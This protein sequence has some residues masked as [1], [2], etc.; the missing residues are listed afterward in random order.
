MALYRPAAVALLLSASAWGADPPPEFAASGVVAGARPAQILAPGAILSIYG[1]YLAAAGSGCVG[2]PDPQRQET[3]NPRQPFR[4]FVNTS[5]YPK[6]LCGVRVMVGEQ[7]AGLLYISEK[8]INFKVPM[9]APESGSADLRV[10]RGGQSSIP[11]RMETGFAKVT[12]SLAHPAYMGMPVWLKV[13]V[14]EFPDL[15]RYPYVLGRAG[16]GC[17]EVE[18]RRNG[19]LLALLP[20]SDWTRRGMVFSGNVCGSYASAREAPGT[21]SL[22]LH[23]LYRF[24]EPG[25][26]EVRYTLW[27]EPPEM[28]HRADFRIQS[29]WTAIKVLPSLPG[30]RAQWLNALRRDPPQDAAALL[31]DV[32]P[33]L[34]GVPDAESLDI[35]TGYLYHPD[36]SVRRYAGNGL[37]YWP[38]D[39]VSRTLEALLRGKGP[40]DA[41]I[42][43]LPRSA[44]IVRASAPSLE[45]DSPVILEGAIAALTWAPQTGGPILDAELRS[46]ERIVPRVDDQSGSN[47]AQRM[48]ESKDPRV[49]ALLR[50]LLEQGHYQVLAGLL[51]FADPGDLPAL[52]DLL[53]ASVND[54]F[55]YLPNEMNRAFGEAALPYFE[56]ALDRSPARFTAREL[57]KELVAA[58]DRA[59]FQYALRVL[60]Q[61]GAERMDMVE[62]LKSQFPEMK[63]AGDETLLAFVTQ[64]S[65][66]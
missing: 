55:S 47:L 37:F 24:D 28:T 39:T 60:Q 56:R 51:Q 3:P 35:L 49:H 58:G 6:E 17:H 64:H 25:T 1:H 12:L 9:D 7:P 27:S 53:N 14:P 42:R 63:S 43:W 40:S 38:D 30:Q 21:G 44:E 45:S 16:F 62:V 2:S 19:T 41:M 10:V 33:G 50:R 11:V 36:A 13:N 26:Y 5:V 29:E 54:R 66:Q 23:L 8:Q 61:R 34:L 22:P 4:M 18:V 57:V 48:A 52:G 15:V 32:L 20:G 31:S 65:Q 59:G 46:A